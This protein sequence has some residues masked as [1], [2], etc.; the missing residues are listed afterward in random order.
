MS[1]QKKDI[2]EIIEN[3]QKIIEDNQKIIADITKLIDR[4]K[5][6]TVLLEYYNEDIK[7]VLDV[8]SKN[9]L[10]NGN[11]IS[12]KNHIGLNPDNIML[13]TYEKNNTDE[14][15]FKY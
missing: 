7:K 2:Q 10:L 5:I 1:L 9:I 11:P 12:D 8:Q 14:T 15:V 4:L 3:N 6:N 13:F